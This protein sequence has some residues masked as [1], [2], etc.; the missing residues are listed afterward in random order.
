MEIDIVESRDL[1]LLGRGQEPSLP[2][3]RPKFG[4]VGTLL[5]TRGLSESEQ[6]N[7][8]LLVDRKAWKFCCDF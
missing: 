4:I 1:P 8:K 3:N 5:S 7:M 2:Q 6:K